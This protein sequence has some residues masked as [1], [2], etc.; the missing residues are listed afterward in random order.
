MQDSMNSY[1][2]SSIYKTPKFNGY[3]KTCAY[4]RFSFLKSLHFASVLDVGSGPCLLHSWLVENNIIVQYE[5]VDIRTNSL[6]LCNCPTYT[7]IP[8]NN[9]Y[10]LVCLF[11]TV[12][13]NIDNNETQNKQVLKDL[14][15]QAKA[16]C[17]KYLLFT[18]FKESIRT[19]YKNNIPKD[20]FVYFSKEEIVNMLSA[21]AVTN[22]TIIENNDLD[23]Q[24]YFVI[25]KLD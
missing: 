24:E 1:S 9:L 18:V 3:G 8:N 10:E 14:L 5:A 13:F 15:Q 21:L 20:F 16:V 17:S 4:K 7:T 12:T 22:F 23:E 2:I 25:C 19:K 6:L 11:G